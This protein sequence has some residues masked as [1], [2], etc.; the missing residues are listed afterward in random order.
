MAEQI[1]KFLIWVTEENS[2]SILTKTS[3]TDSTHP[4]FKIILNNNKPYPLM[5]LDYNNL[6]DEMYNLYVANIYSNPFNLGQLHGIFNSP[7][8]INLIY[9]RIYYLVIY[10][11]KNA[12]KDFKS[13]SFLTGKIP[14][15]LNYLVKILFIIE[16][17]REIS[18]DEIRNFY[19]QLFD[20]FFNLYP[21]LKKNFIITHNYTIDQLIDLCIS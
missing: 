15:S 8:I 3:N 16:N 2:K 1:S 20:E 6:P 5:D 11:E 21:D 19:H 9:E 7:S 18:E 14:K 12:L 10:S 4:I 17:T 13:K